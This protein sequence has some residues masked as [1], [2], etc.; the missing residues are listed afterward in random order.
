MA[1]TLWELEGGWVGVQ[2]LSKRKEETLAERRGVA[3]Q[4]R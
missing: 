3:V 1:G 4:K 2:D